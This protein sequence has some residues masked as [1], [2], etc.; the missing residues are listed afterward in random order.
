MLVLVVE[1]YGSRCG[2]PRGGV[3]VSGMLGVWRV[4][5]M[6]GVSGVSEV[7]E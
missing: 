4:W 2:V 6:W 5:W 7:T 3:R 1:V